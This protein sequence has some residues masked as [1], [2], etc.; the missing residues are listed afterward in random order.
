MSLYINRQRC[1]QEATL[2][3]VPISVTGSITRTDIYQ[4][5][6]EL[7]VAASDLAER[8]EAVIVPSPLTVQVDDPADPF[9]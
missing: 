3:R 4:H 6:P 1:F 9:V 8:L 5:E 2:T 7:T